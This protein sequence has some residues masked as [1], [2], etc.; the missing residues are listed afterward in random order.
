MDPVRNP[1]APGAGNPPP[2]LAGRK[3]VLHSATT[4]LLRI[5]QGRP[6]QSLILVGLRGVGKTVL[7]NRI[8]QLA[9]DQN[10]LTI[11]IEAH[12]GKSL[13]ALLVPGL[14]TALFK[15]SSIDRAKET[16]RRGLRVL[17]SFLGGLKIS[18]E[19]VDVGIE[20]ETGSADSGD[21]EADLPE[22]I[23]SVA[24][25]AKTAN[26]P[27]IILIDELQYLTEKEF[28]ALIMSVHRTNQ[29]NL[30]LLA[31]VSQHE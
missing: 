28:S 30:P 1:Y 11:F 2:E 25:A 6:T 16:S 29:K 31:R 20:A 27:I 26:K 23:L 5:A 24:T 18:V 19:G 22:L 14:R 21:I 3:D 10:F 17:K 12:E 13:P 4:A 15:L 7:L 8:E 9:G